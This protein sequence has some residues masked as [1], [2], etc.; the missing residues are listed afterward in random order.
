MSDLGTLNNAGP[1]GVLRSGHEPVVYHLSPGLVLGR[2]QQPN[3]VYTRLV[4]VHLDPQ[5][6]G[7]RSSVFANKIFSVA[8]AGGGSRTVRSC[9]VFGIFSMEESATDHMVVLL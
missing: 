8:C 9:V 7:S 5:F 4:P 3:A 2:Q 1:I 6:S